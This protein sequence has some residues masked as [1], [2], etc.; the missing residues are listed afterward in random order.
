M[1]SNIQM[2]ATVFGGLAIFLY[3]M[4]LMSDGLREAAGER[5]KA[6]LGYMTRNRFFAILAGTIV[7]GLIQS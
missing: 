3:G 2:F 7:T 6:I 1:S 5:M 4:T